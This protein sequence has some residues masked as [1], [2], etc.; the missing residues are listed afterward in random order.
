MSLNYLRDRSHKRENLGLVNDNASRV[1]NQESQPVRS[2]VR[3]YASDHDL[4]HGQI[5]NRT[6]R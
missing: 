3:G 4:P 1:K 2:C 5:A 6:R